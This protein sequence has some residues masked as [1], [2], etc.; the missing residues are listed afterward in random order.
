MRTVLALLVL[1]AVAAAGTLEVPAEY[2]TIQAAVNAAGPGDTVRIAAV[3]SPSYVGAVV[4]DGKSDLAIVG[5]GMPSL[6]GDGVAVPLRLANC[7]RILVTGLGFG[8]GVPADMQIYY[9]Q[10]VTITGCSIGNAGAGFGIH[11]EGSTGL[12]ITKNSIGNCQYG[13]V[14]LS[15]DI[16]DKIASSDCLISGNGFYNC[17]GSIRVMGDGIRIEK[18]TIS[19]ETE[20]AISV[21]S[22]GSSGCQVLKNTIYNPIGPADGIQVDGTGHVISGNRITGGGVAIFASCTLSTITGNRIDGVTDAGIVINDFCDGLSVVKN[23]IAGA[24]A[25]GIDEYGHETTLEG[26][27]ITGPSGAGMRIAGAECECLGNKVSMSAANGVMV[28][29]GAFTC[30]FLG[31]KVSKSGDTGFDVM[32]GGHFFEGNSAK[33]SGSLDLSDEGGPGANTYAGNK[34]G[35]SNL[36]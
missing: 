25:V 24:M 35:T 10:D 21:V 15:A 2:A 18:N 11:D 29:G 3:P 7:Q 4:V 13:G 14:S 23:K 27:S 6:E 17:L 16:K 33:G 12:V 36:N 20:T 30:R 5:S 28:L 26:N 22:M 31:N 1:T 19:R 9:C 8:N 34:F 32:S